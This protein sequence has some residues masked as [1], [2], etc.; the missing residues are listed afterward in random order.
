MMQFQV[1]SLAAVL[2]R[3]LYT[4][5]FEEFWPLLPAEAQASVKQEMLACIQQ[6]ENPGVRRKMCDCT[7]E[8]A[9]NMIGEV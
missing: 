7:A 3:R 1:R 8:L 9:R 6:E 5:T 2:L 4:S